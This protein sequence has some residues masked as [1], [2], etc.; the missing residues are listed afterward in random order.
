MKGVIGIFREVRDPRR[1]NARH[2]LAE[3]LFIALAATLCGAKSC[4]DMADF[5]AARLE[6]L[7]EIVDLPHGAPSHDTFS[8]VFAV[9][10]PK[11]LAIAFEGFLTAIREA[12]GLPKPNGVVAVDGKS[13]RRA[14]EKGRAYMPPLMVG[15][16]DNRT[17]L[18]IAQTRAPGG[19]EV[20]A[21]LALLKGLV[22]KGATVTADALHARPEMA[23]ACRAAK[24]HYALFL[25]ANQ[26]NLLKAVEA[27]F[28]RAGGTV[29]TYE[30]TDTR[31]G[32]IERRCAAVV[33]AG[34]LAGDHG[35]P[36]LAC[37]A[38]IEAQRTSAG[39]GTK[40]MTRYML[41]SRRL[42]PRKALEISREH[43]G[44]EN[45]LHWRLDVVFDEDDSRSRKSYA[46]ENLAVLRRM[47]L[48]IL[49]AHP[50]AKSIARK[51]KQAA[52]SKPFFLELFTQM[53]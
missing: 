30:T 9:L 41:H 42:S 45:K 18:A 29:A 25:K 52:W 4:V 1:K 10:D 17:R 32:R 16:W 46:P 20:G 13:L 51:M 49:Q 44:I 11:E 23:A 6:S 35:W 19:D 5:A 24:A 14:Y 3:I 39:G 38:R 15:V 50:S 48:N 28:G 21:T 22:L 7:R 26:P 53:R 12:L 27:A 37:L 33:D 2:D 43:W 31:H 36:D 8:R 47:A 34:H 40:T